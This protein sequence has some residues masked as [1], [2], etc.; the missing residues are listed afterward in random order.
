M[1]LVSASKREINEDELDDIVHP[2]L[3]SSAIRGSLCVLCVGSIPTDPENLEDRIRDVVIE[4]CKKY[5]GENPSLEFH[6][7]LRKEGIVY[8]FKD[9]DCKPLPDKDFYRKRITECFQHFNDAGEEVV[10]KNKSDWAWIKYAMDSGL[11]VVPKDIQEMSNRDYIVF[12]RSIGAP[13]CPSVNSHFS[14][15]GGRINKALLGKKDSDF[16]WK[17]DDIKDPQER[18]RRNAIVK[19]F[20]D[21]I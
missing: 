6:L 20:M 13:K 17:Y 7:Y 14:T 21:S 9:G 5:S 15:I 10:I 4:E 8:L 16:P 11:V 1:Y 2:E 19:K 18:D 12:L 3:T